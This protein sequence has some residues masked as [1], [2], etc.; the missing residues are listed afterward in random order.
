MF[1]TSK[2]T[3]TSV[4]YQVSF[5]SYLTVCCSDVEYFQIPPTAC[6]EPR[7]RHL[8]ACFWTAGQR[9][10]PSSR[11]AFVWRVKSTDTYSDG[12]SAMT[13]DNWGPGEP[14]YAYQAESCMHLA[15][16]WSYMW[17]D[18]DCPAAVCSVCELDI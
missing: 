16:G 5:A 3:Y 12:V 14:N 10:D 15:S 17:N 2:F 6:R 18:L 11:S 13:Y 1:I 7:Y 4:L 8:G 9:I